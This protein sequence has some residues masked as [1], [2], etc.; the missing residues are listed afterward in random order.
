M[1]IVF[2]CDPVIERELM[3]PVAGRAA[4]P[5]WLRTMPRTA[6]SDLHGQEVRAVKQCPPFVDAMSHG[7]IIPLP[8]DVTVRDGVLSWD[9]DHPALTVEAHPRSPVSFHVPAQ[10]A[11]TPFYDPDVAIVKFNSFWTIELEPGYSPFA[12]HPVNRAGDRFTDVG[13]LFPA[14]WTDA[15]FEGVLPRG[16]PIAQCFPVLREA[17]ELQFQAFSADTPTQALKSSTTTRPPNAAH[18]S[19]TQDTGKAK[20]RRLCPQRNAKVSRGKREQLRAVLDKKQSLPRRSKPRNAIRQILPRSR[21]KKMV[22]EILGESIS[23][24]IEHNATIAQQPALLL[25]DSSIENRKLTIL[26]SV[27]LR[28][29]EMKRRL[30]RHNQRQNLSALLTTDVKP[31][32]VIEFE[33]FIQP[34]GENLSNTKGPSD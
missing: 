32:A 26:I 25:E 4:L 14:V 10:V 6:F 11:G 16:A 19:R 31:R 17:L 7:F 15:D 24:K 30:K 23:V 3:R 20:C 5:D 1:R 27:I 34:L 21:F 29:K 22:V 8:C 9:W 33:Y 2:R 28:K 18:T 12:T 13:I